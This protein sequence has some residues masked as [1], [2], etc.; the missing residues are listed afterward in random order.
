MQELQFGQLRYI[1]KYPDGFSEEKKHPVLFFLHGAGTR[2]TDISKLTGNPFFGIIEQHENFPFICVAPQCSENTW[3]DLWEQLKKLVVEISQFPYVDRERIYV[4]G[5]SMG[6]YATWQLAMSMPEYFAAIVPICG[7]GM[8]WNAARLVDVPVWAFHGGKDMT[9]R[10][11][12]SVKMVDAVNRHGGS[13]KLTLYPENGHNAWSD[14]YANMEV[15]SW[16]LHQ[17]R[18]SKPEYTDQYK[19]SGVYG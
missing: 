17:K 4:M 5:A 19:N 7:G 10:A 3:F 13:A 9:V 16:L 18:K 2:G 15:F 1:I 11:E 6:G 14:T 12:E 8:Y